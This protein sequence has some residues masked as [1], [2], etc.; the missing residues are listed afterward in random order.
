MAADQRILDMIAHIEQGQQHL[1]NTVNNINATQAQ[2]QAQNV[3]G[4][5]HRRRGKDLKPPRYRGGDESLSWETFKSQWRTYAGLRYGGQ[6]TNE[7]IEEMKGTLYCSIGG[8]ASQLLTGLGPNTPAFNGAANLEQ[9]LDQLTAVFRPATEVSLA[10]QKFRAR[11]Q[12]SAE[13]VQVYWSVKKRL[14]ETA[15]PVDFGAGRLEQFL[16]GFVDG[17]CNDQVFERVKDQGPYN[18]AQEVLDAALKAVATQRLAVAQGRKRDAGGLGT[19]VFQVDGDEPNLGLK[20]KNNDTPE[21][22]D[23]SYINQINDDV[24]QLLEDDPE[25]V[26]DI[27]AEHL[28]QINL[29]GEFKGTCWTC[30]DYGHSSRYCPKKSRFNRGRGATPRGASGSR[31]IRKPFRRP[32]GTSLPRRDK[33]GQFLPAGVY[34]RKNIQQLFNPDDGRATDEDDD[35]DDGNN[36]NEDEEEEDE[37][38]EG[39]GA[40]N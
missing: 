6:P 22:M 3:G 8:V 11:K 13:S 39:P 9:Y 4:G 33:K 5:G 40:G 38:E 15:Y 34:T 7:D 10:K 21:K 32:A 12:N 20:N 35:D 1:V 23:M 26:A 36:N 16:E 31:S 29:T 19:T 27:V 28:S 30:Q 14:F 17:L 18:T 25:S 2:V 37:D 24:D